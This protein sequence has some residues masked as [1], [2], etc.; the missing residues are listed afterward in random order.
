MT[1]ITMKLL[2]VDGRVPD[3]ETIISSLNDS[4]ACLVFNYYRDTPETLLSKI[5]FLNRRN[6]VI[7]E[8]F[9]YDEP[10]ASV[11]TDLSNCTTCD[12]SGN[13]K[14]FMSASDIALRA[15]EYALANG[16][17]GSVA[18]DANGDSTSP[19]KPPTPWLP[20]FSD[21]SVPPPVFFQRLFPVTDASG[22]T[23][24]YREQLPVM[25][26]D[27]DEIYNTFKTIPYESS[28]YVYSD[29]YVVTETEFSSVGIIQHAYMMNGN[30]TYTF[31][32]MINAKEDAVAVGA[33]DGALL[34]DVMSIDPNLLTWQPLVSTLT[35]ILTRH[36]STTLDLM[37]CAIYADPNWK[38][39][40]DEL[41]RRMGITIR[42]S[43]DNTGASAMGG[44]WILETDNVNLT[45]VY[46]TD[47]IN[48][49]S[50]LLAIYTAYDGFVSGPTAQSTSNNW[51]Y[52]EIDSTR[53]TASLL[54]NWQTGNEIISTYGQWDNNRTSGNYPFIQRVTGTGTINTGYGTSI[55]GPALVIHPDDSANGNIG[56]GYKN[57][58]ASTISVAVDISLSFLYPGNNTDGVNY[59]IQRGLVNDARFQSY[60]SSSI[61]ASS[62]SVYTFN[63]TNVELQS[64]E[65]V[66][67]IVNRNGIYYWDHLRL[68][69]SI[70]VTFAAVAPTFGTFTVASTKTYGDASF[71]IITRPTSNSPGAITYTSN[72]TS[73][74][75]IDTSGNWITLVGAGNV[76]FTATQNASGGYTS[77]SVT[78]NTLTVSLGTP[79]L[80]TA[81]FSV[82]STKVYGDASF[83]ITTRPTSNSDGAITYTSN[84]A[85]VATIDACGNWINIISVGYVSFNATQ[86]AV[87][88]KFTSATR[89][90]NT[91]TVSKAN[92]T[93]TFSNPPSTKN[94]TD[95]AFTVSASSG[96]SPGAVTYSSSNTAF[97]TVGASTGLVTLT[98]AGTVTI[99]ATQASTALYNSATATCSIVI[100]AAGSTLAGQTVSPGTSF[101]GVD[102]SGASFAGTTLSGVSFSGATLTNVNFSGA[103]ITGTDFTN[104]NISGATNLPAFSTVQKLQLLKNINNASNGAV[105]VPTVT[106]SSLSGALTTSISGIDALTFKVV[107]PTTVDA[108]NNKTVTIT[109]ADI[110]SANIY[111]PVN[112]ADTIKINGTSV[113]TS[114]GT[115]IVDANNAVVSYISI[116]G[117]PF[118]VYAGS[119]VAVNIGSQ[120]NGLKINNIGL[121]DVMKNLYS[122]NTGTLTP[123]TGGRVSQATLDKINIIQLGDNQAYAVLKELFYTNNTVSD[124]TYSGSNVSAATI[125]AFNT[126]KINGTSLYSILNKLFV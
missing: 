102:L 30:A 22:T 50:H 78:S 71:A 97:A 120:L 41:E 14:Q 124:T 24:M 121:F 33:A 87:A 7:R 98:G 74:A 115:N 49:W 95:A 53:S 28:P 64:G 88:N 3:I 67:L 56:I 91:L 57:T 104:A 46:F 18:T 11:I 9:L 5:R 36:Q 48:S 80:S 123:Y 25:V 35:T 125:A 108:S 20:S 122:I 2:L 79:T 43:T 106:G 83:A 54:S 70:N 111:L 63:N 103:V 58:T 39:V 77:G 40:I 69:F 1:T 55:T 90:S 92:P 52:F 119:L 27:L 75:T 37:A 101:S 99:T 114:N 61:P 96:V 72:S 68:G 110:T 6:R 15:M 8:N 117:I 26:S 66:Y 65:I 4:T 47:G 105:Q 34:T 82:A 38:Y 89:S 32:K 93:L 23:I 59:Y 13:P 31:L 116:D 118:R 81:T 107:V 85:A 84:N 29:T 45:D 94:V 76:T 42:A 86:A 16:N 60:A 126:I 12:A 112:T 21:N 73:I 100:S 113:Y 51:Q 10:S 19:Q 109:S 17:S 44:N 62:S